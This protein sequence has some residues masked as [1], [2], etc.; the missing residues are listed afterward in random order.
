MRKKSSIPQERPVGLVWFCLGL[1]LVKTDLVI[2][3]TGV[4]YATAKTTIFS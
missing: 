3:Y 1:P 2:C 4:V